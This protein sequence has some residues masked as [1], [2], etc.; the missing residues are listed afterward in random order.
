MDYLNKLISKWMPPES[1]RVAVDSHPRLSG[2]MDTINATL[3]H[4]AET[5]LPKE[6]YDKKGIEIIEKIG[7]E[8]WFS[9]FQE[10]QE[11][12]QVGIGGLVGDIVSRMIGHIEG[13]GGD[14]LGEVGD[15]PET[16]RGGETRIKFGL[17][18]CHDT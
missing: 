9:G 15:E 17:S 1:P 7:V 4:G 8:E 13:H 2:I 3:S 10:S 18:G 5:R 12:R 16:G 14:G 6:F 11:Y